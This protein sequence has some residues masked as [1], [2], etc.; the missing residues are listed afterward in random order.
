MGCNSIILVGQDLPFT[1]QKAHSKDI[2]SQDII[3]SSSPEDV[4]DIYGK[5]IKN[6]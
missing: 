1:D 6:I 2:F 5:T 4:E 3:S